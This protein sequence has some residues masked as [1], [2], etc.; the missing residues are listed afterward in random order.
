M[1][2]LYSSKWLFFKTTTT[3][4]KDSSVLPTSLPYNRNLPVFS[5]LVITPGTSEQNSGMYV[6]SVLNAQN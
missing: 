5:S 1:I 4:T 6:G 2:P 3:T